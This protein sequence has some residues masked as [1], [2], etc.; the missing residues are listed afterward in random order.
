M[1]L[2]TQRFFYLA[3]LLW[4]PIMHELV[5]DSCI[6]I[7]TWIMLI[8]Y[9]AHGMLL[10]AKADLWFRVTQQ[11]RH[12]TTCISYDA[13]KPLHRL[14]RKRHCK[15]LFDVCGGGVGWHEG[16]ACIHSVLLS[17]VTASQASLFCIFRAFTWFSNY[18]LL[19]IIFDLVA[20]SCFAVCHMIVCDSFINSC[21]PVGTPCF[22]FVK[23]NA[24]H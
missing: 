14:L 2:Q 3:A 22:A 9:C 20:D 8:F 10:L 19:L 13:F 11:W 23:C 21:G 1:C 4:T 15:T 12:S 16:F 18:I 6:W 5:S 7:C 24:R 17:L